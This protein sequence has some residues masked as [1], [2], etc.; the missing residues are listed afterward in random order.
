MKKFNIKERLHSNKFFKSV[1]VLT[2]GTAIAQVVNVL[3]QPIISRIYTPE[4]VGTFA[5][6][7]AIVSIIGTI[8]LGRYDL[9]VLLPKEKKKSNAIIILGTVICIALSLVIF[10]VSFVFKSQFLHLLALPVSVKYWV[11][12]FGILVLVFGLDLLY[13]R[14]LIREEL[15]SFLSI[16]RVIRQLTTN[17]TKVGLG[18]FYSLGIHGLFIA[19]VLG[20]AVRFVIVFFKSR[21]F[22]FTKT[23]EDKVVV[24]DIKDVAVRYKKF[25]LV[26]TWSALLNVCS[27]SLPI[28]LFKVLYSSEVSGL[29][30]FTNAIMA[31]PISIVGGSVANVFSR[32]AAALHAEKKSLA[33]LTFSL[34]K[35]MFAMGC[36]VMSFV[37][38]Y[39]WFL[40]PFVFGEKWALAGQYAQWMSVP[41]IFMFVFSPLSHLFNILEKQSEGL[42]FN[43]ILLIS[44]SLVIIVSSKLILKT[45]DCV[46]IFFVTSALVYLIF[47]IRIVY[48]SGVKIYDLFKVMFFWLFAVFSL[49]AGIFFVLNFFIDF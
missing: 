17:L 23:T 29:Y 20:N 5:S 44:R 46:A 38:F 26:S 33:N 3:F 32:E 40:F 8:S 16:S 11:Y 12:L 37:T 41:L 49:Q 35:K 9:A 47:C 31:L 25:P 42:L 21:K 10:F 13:N 39:G 27:T 19:T 1:L 28:I 18:F 4:Q 24:T 7:F 48:L 43:F 2:S 34:Y 22:V 36:L 6:Y 45:I 30:S 15:Y 14:V